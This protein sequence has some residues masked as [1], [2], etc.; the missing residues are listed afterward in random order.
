M[1]TSDTVEM[2]NPSQVRGVIGGFHFKSSNMFRAELQR[3]W[4]MLGLRD[5]GF[6]VSTLDSDGHMH[7]TMK[8]RFSVEGERIDRVFSV[9][10]NY[11]QYHMYSE[12]AMEAC[13]EQILLAAKEYLPNEPELLVYDDF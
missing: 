9:S 11:I 5:T 2:R 10:V 3:L 13:K 12:L 6:S 1:T 7:M 4:T 8:F